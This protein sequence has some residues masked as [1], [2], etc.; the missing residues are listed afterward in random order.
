MALGRAASQPATTAE[1]LSVVRRRLDT[2]IADLERLAGGRGP[3]SLEAG[4][5]GSVLR[6]V[7]DTDLLSVDVDGPVGLE[8]PA[9][10]VE[11]LA[12]VASECIVN[13]ARHGRARRF[14]IVVEVVGG[15]VDVSLRDDG[16]GGAHLR[17]GG[18]LDGLRRRV[19]ALGGVME[20]DSSASGT[21]IMVRLPVSVPSPDT[22]PVEPERAAQPAQSG[23][24]AQLG[25]ADCQ[26]WF[27]CAGAGYHDELGGR[28]PACEGADLVRVDLAGRR[29]AIVLTRCD[30]GSVESA[31]GRLRSTM[32]DG[33][34]AAIAA[35][36]A[37]HLVRE[38]QRIDRRMRAAEAV[39][40]RRLTERSVGHL[41]AALHELD[42]SD[43]LPSR[44]RTAANHV[45]EATEILRQVVHR[46]RS[47]P[48][49]GDDSRD[50]LPV[51][52]RDIASRLGVV[53][54]LSVEEGPDG[55]VEPAVVQ[56]AEELLH[57]A[58]DQPG[59]RLS[60]RRRRG[61]TVL[62]CTRATLPDPMSLALLEDVV[63]HWGGQVSVIAG[64]DSVT[65]EAQVTA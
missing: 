34:C 27:W 64:A 10:V 26:V 47:G 20:V 1:S 18:G 48:P 29:A 23:L 45:E 30:P 9:A 35:T 3:R 32:A 50:S 41:Q 39:M 57:L 14:A 6:A 54:T 15:Y 55:V 36:T 17:L 37:M 28:A 16:R 8:L 2:V 46:L 21:T 56:V 33:W 38:R 31:W 25:D 62:R 42:V 53:A 4:D 19:V 63:A 60:I 43:P 22:D 5:V 40:V 52:V 61:V 44:C 7:A 59:G 51:V 58:H 65:I 12:F 11:L 49:D 13:A 24:R